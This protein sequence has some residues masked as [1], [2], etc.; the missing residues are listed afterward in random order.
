MQYIICMFEKIGGITGKRIHIKRITGVKMKGE[1]GLSSGKYS[2]ITP[3]SIGLYYATK[4]DILN[5]YG[6]TTLDKFMQLMNVQGNYSSIMRYENKFGILSFNAG[7]VVRIH[8][9]PL[10][11]FNRVV[12]SYGHMFVNDIERYHELDGEV[13]IY[14]HDKYDEMVKLLDTVN[15]LKTTKEEK[16]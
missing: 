3:G 9:Y 14:I 15:T 10:E 5:V 11:Y 6:C 12:Q 2:N 4:C 7:R 8:Q 1:Y 13:I 16:K